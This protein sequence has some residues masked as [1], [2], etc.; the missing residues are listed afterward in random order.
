MNK[1]EKMQMQLHFAV[2]FVGGFLGGYAI[3]NHS[4]IFANAQTANLIHIVA[5][6][7]SS[8][9]SGLILLFASLAAYMAGNAFYVLAEKYIN[10]DMRVLSLA[11][12]SAAVVAVGIIPGVTNDYIILLPILFVTPI[13]WNAFRTAAGYV[14]STIFSS[15]NLRQA[16]MSFVNYMLD[17]DK[18]QLEKTKFYW[19]TILL[20]HSGVAVACVAGINVGYA[21]IWFCF[22]PVAIA[23]AAYLHLTGFNFGAIIKKESEA[24]AK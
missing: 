16:T 12:D 11:L 19:T 21:S 5:K 7:F 13:Q 20:F 14:S 15:N 2:S 4:D 18:K 22:I 8:D 1:E 3:I 23:F 9:F 24:G 6:I 17:K 10:I